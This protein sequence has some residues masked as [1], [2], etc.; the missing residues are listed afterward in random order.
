MGGGTIFKAVTK[1]DMQGI[2]FIVPNDV[3]VVRFEEIVL[4][5]EG[6]IENLT[7]KSANLRQTLEPPPP[8]TH[9][10]RVKRIQSGNP[11]S[12]GGP[13]ESFNGGRLY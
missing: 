12:R 2:D 4:P 8:Q 5:M 10:R 11:Y 7:K 1:K 6:E 9:L 13:H 3:I